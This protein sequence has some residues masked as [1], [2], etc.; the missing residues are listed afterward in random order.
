[1]LVVKVCI[2]TESD[3]KLKL[4]NFVDYAFKTYIKQ[5]QIDKFCGSNVD[6]KF[7]TYLMTK[8]TNKANHN[9]KVNGVANMTVF[10]FFFF[11]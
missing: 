3:I 10:Y 8:I 9:S 11:F 5:K 1:M 2:T 7:E 4:R 6:V